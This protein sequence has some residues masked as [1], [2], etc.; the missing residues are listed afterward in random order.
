MWYVIVWNNEILLWNY[1]LPLNHRHHQRLLNF[2]PINKR[3]THIHSVELKYFNC[4]KVIWTLVNYWSW[5]MANIEQ[6]GMNSRKIKPGLVGP[7]WCRSGED[8]EW[9]VAWCVELTVQQVSLLQTASS[10]HLSVLQGIDPRTELCRWVSS[11]LSASSPSKAGPSSKY[12]LF[13]IL[14]LQ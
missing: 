12:F 8:V 2:S 5:L 13:K 1:I 11:S 6:I 7:I 4:K 10:S 14:Y 9:C 3:K